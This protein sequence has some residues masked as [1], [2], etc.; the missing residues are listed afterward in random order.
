VSVQEERELR[1][2]LGGLLDG[3]EP[4]SAPV[5]HA[6]RQGRG[7]RMRRWTAAGAGLAVIAAGALALPAIL[8][9]H[10]PT[11][12]PAASLHFTVTVNPPQAGAN[13]GV[14]AVGSVNGKPWEATLT[15]SGKDLSVGFGGDYPFM[16]VGQQTPIP[17]SPAAT[18]DAE[19]GAMGN[20]A[21][22]GQ[23]SPPV[24]YLAVTLSDREVLI[25]R[26]H[27][28]HGLR[29][30]AMVLPQKLDVAKAVAYGQAGEMGYA[31]PFNFGGLATF[32]HWLRPG[33]AGLARQA[34]RLGSGTS[35][36]Q[37][38]SAMAYQG[39]WGI[40]TEIVVPHGYNG[41]CTDAG[42][43]TAL[44]TPWSGG[45]VAIVAFARSD[46]AYLLLT[47][48]DRSVVRAPVS[49][50]AGYGMFVVGNQRKPAVI[51]W[52][53]YAANGSRLGG[54]RGNPG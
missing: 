14:I 44:T 39:P 51:S 8:N 6:M 40:C 42:P 48:S 33:Q 25:L 5:F 50:L 30:V 46:V 38:W 3:I 24:R 52:Q 20:A 53:A 19:T 41:A 2:R 23:V 18:I 35:D 4:R 45:G 37:H 11:P 16:T 13:P 27:A 29:Y 34:A 54:G 49:H 22:L 26:P 15:G 43:Q 21:Y 10:N 28:W 31:I 12:R 32:E 9:A 1:E 17:K 7:I 47:M 36:G